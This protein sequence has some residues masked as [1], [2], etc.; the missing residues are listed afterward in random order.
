MKKEEYLNLVEEQIRFRRARE[1]VRREL[2]A[3]IDDQTEYFRSQGMDIS[4]AEEAAVCEMG[5]PVETG[6]RMDAIYRP[7]MAWKSI[8]AII[9]ISLVTFF[10]QYVL[11]NSMPDALNMYSAWLPG[12]AAKNLLM[13]IMGWGVMIGVC[14]LDYTRI[15]KYAGVL[16]IGGCVGILLLAKFC[17]MPVNG[18]NYWFV[19]YGYSVS[20]RMVC[21]LFLPLYG[22]VLYRYRGQGYKGLFAGALWMLPSLWILR[23]ESAIMIIVIVGSTYLVMLTAAV[24]K[25]WFRVPKSAAVAGLWLGAGALVYGWMNYIKFFG[26]AYQA[27]RLGIFEDAFLLK[28]GDTVT[29]VMMRKLLAG[30]RLFGTKKGFIGD[31]EGI[32]YPGEYALSLICAFYGILAAVVLTA[33]IALLFLHFFKM[34]FRQKNQ[35]GMIM[36][37]GCSTVFLVQLL[38]YIMGNLG[39]LLSGASYCPFLGYGGS[40][41]VVTY[42]LL[43]ILLSIYRY[44]DVAPEPEAKKALPVFAGQEKGRGC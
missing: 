13:H 17:A 27:A 20:V 42:I 43:G 23:M 32:M 7:K 5:D 28:G 22:A 19:G 29:S 1:G 21:F 2:A 10:L 38:L 37:T 3:H 44:E 9:L 25:G 6:N 39:M 26:P 16:M 40:G 4:E 14:Y 15:G 35:L 30:S 33:V 31:A 34:S 12:G 36:G 11:T 18:A 41:A 24:W 8:A